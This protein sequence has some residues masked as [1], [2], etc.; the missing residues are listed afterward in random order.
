MLLFITVHYSK[1]QNLYKKTTL[2]ATICCILPLVV[3][4]L[5]FAFGGQRVDHSSMPGYQDKSKTSVGTSVGDISPEFQLTDITGKKFSKSDFQEKPMILW[6]T[7][8][9]CVP[10]QIGAKEVK[11]L[12]DDMGG[13]AFDVTMVFIDS[14]ET[15]QDLRW[16]K[17]NFGDTDWYIAFGN[18]QIISDHKIRYLD[19]QY[20]LDKNGVI[21]NVANSNVGYEGYKNKIQPLIQ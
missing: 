8:S 16:W 13:S 1:S 21:K 2:L 5:L 20:L 6:F 17:E 3:I 4:G 11:R 10:C 18:E 14:R 12:D 15:E 9:Y 19:T 7:A